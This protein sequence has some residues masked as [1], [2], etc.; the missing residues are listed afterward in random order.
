MSAHSGVPAPVES[1]EPRS[2]CYDAATEEDVEFNKEFRHCFTTVDDVQMHYVVGGEGSQVM[3]LLHG[4]P[5]SWYVYRD[6][7]PSLLPGRTVIAIDLPGMGDS[8]GDPS[9]M[10]R[11]VLAGYVHQLLN[12]LGYRENVQVVAHDFGVGVAY[13]LAAQYREQVA[14]LFLMDFPLVG[15]RLKFADFAPLS[16]HFSFNQ[17]YPLAEE[18]VRGRV[19][20]FMS[21]LFAPSETG[22][23]PASD[24][25]L[26]EYV[27]VFSRPQVLHAGFEL[28]RTWGQD[29]ID[30]TEFQDSP[31]TIPVRMLTTVGFAPI[32]LPALQDAAP[33]AIGSAVPDVGHHLV[34]E[35]P[36]HVLAEINAFFSIP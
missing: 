34:H 13:A 9:S 23:I 31:L 10:A 22:E 30:N 25:E 2:P 15:K 8:T 33:Q 24:A 29:E 11:A 18:M 6:I 28:Y 17:Q 12:H 21:F 36:D 26:A 4:W 7:M 3:V 16:W 32:T 1:E 14:G 27:R 19:E 20:T 5:H 35:A